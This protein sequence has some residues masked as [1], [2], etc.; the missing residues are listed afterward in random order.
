MN[1]EYRSAIA[2]PS[3]AAALLGIDPD[4][5]E[6]VPAG[7]YVCGADGTI[8]GYN[9]RATELWGR[10]PGLRDNDERFCGSFR[11]HDLDGNPIP[12]ARTPMA[13]ALRTGTACRGEHVVIEH[14]NG[15]RL[16]VVVHIAPLKDR[17]GRI[18]GAVNCFED[19]TEQKRAER[20]LEARVEEQGAIYRLTD[21]LLRAR[22]EEEVYEAALDAILGAL[23]CDRASI[24]RLD[25][26]GGMQFVAWRGLSD[27]YRAAAAGHSPWIADIV[28]AQPI[29]VGD[30]A[31]ADIDGPLRDKID[32]EGIAALA[33]IPLVA[34]GRL[35][36]KFMACYDRPRDFTEGEVQLAVTIARQL[37]FS[38]ERLQAEEA[39]R[40]AVREL[41][42]SEARERAHAAELQTIMDAIPAVMLVAEDPE[43]RVV[44]GNYAA[45]DYLRLTGK[46]NFSLSAE[47][48]ERPSHYRVLVDGRV[49]RPDELPVQRAAG[50]EE[51]SDFEH[52][53]RFDDGTS[54]YLLGNARPLPDHDGRPRGAVAAFIDITER[55]HAEEQRAL[56]VAEL[57]HRVKNTL[58]TV[59]SV[60]QQS[61]AR[62][63]DME[64][65]LASFNSRIRALAQTHTRLAESNWSGA[66]LE[67]ILQDELT[68]YLRD[69]G[70]NV[71]ISGPPLPL[72]ARCA[73]TL[74]M[75]IH[76][77]A[78]NAAKYGSLSAETGMLEVRWE[79]DRQADSV[80]IHWRE[81]G[82]PEV[83][84][85]DRSGF[86][87]LLLER[88]LQVELG[89]DVVLDFAPSGF[90]CDIAI[91]LE[92]SAAGPD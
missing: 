87:R 20:E 52:E 89:G 81:S 35:I 29:C 77:L 34:E 78:T 55:K 59:I 41:R 82:G 84:S 12:H 71:H 54:R 80:S 46:S 22:A 38:I 86:G 58:A 88:A 21:S 64:E 67:D 73:L 5:L 24:L 13:E 50:G 51:I 65:A 74:G 60:A 7:L 23:R 10:A 1:S 79:A 57:N 47:G 17:R 28:D 44:K 9:R 63:D 25:G 6:V 61:F 37:G 66:F 72:G 42:E 32:S 15:T 56:L 4:V 43:C 75:I 11:L 3:G 26:S 83:E 40:A 19:A 70:R 49:L 92:R 8:L 85:P 36:G 18:I 45:V 69:E 27:G 62:R 30:I 31:D 33:F 76:E 68:P 48:G 14:P 2:A 91:P 90:R 16:I 39:R 53:I